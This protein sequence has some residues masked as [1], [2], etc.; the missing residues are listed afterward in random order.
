MQMSALL[1]IISVFVIALT[2]IFYNFGELV[3]VEMEN[4]DK[5]EEK[6]PV[7]L[8]TEQIILP[9]NNNNKENSDNLT[10]SIG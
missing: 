10:G 8:N 2:V 3:S 1:R 5:T 7:F 4:S 6:K 9:E